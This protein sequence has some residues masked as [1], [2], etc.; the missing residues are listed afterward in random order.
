MP[1]TEDPTDTPLSGLLS[2]PDSP[3]VLDAPIGAGATGTVYRAHLRRPLGTLP[4]ESQVAVKFLNQRFAGDPGAQ[5][6]LLEEGRLGQAI[7]SAYVARIHGVGT[8]RVLG[9]SVTWLVMEYLEGDNL[10]TFVDSGRRAVEDLTRRVGR[11]AALGLA[12]LHARGIVHRDVKP[13]NLHLT[14]EGTVK[15]MDL[16]LAQRI[17]RADL[18]ASAGPAGTLPYS[19]PEVL[20]GRTATPQSDLWALGIVLYEL[21]TGRHPFARGVARGSG[22]QGTRDG[23]SHPGASSSTGSRRGRSA[24]EIIEAVLNATP[25]RPSHRQPR[26]SA[27]L[28]EVILWLMAKDP[29]ARPVAASQLAEILDQ[30]EASRWWIERMARAPTLAAR[31]R[32]RRI[33]RSAPGPFVDRESATRQLDRHHRALLRGRG[34]LVAISGPSGIG[35]RRLLDEA[36]EAWLDRRDA[37]SFVWGVASSDPD[38]GRGQPFPAMLAEALLGERPRGPRVRERIESRLGTRTDWSQAA[39]TRVAGSLAGDAAAL[40]PAD[41]AA[42]FV[43]LLEVL[44]REQPIVLRIDHA[45]HLDGTALR[46]LDLVHRQRHGLPILVLLV[47]GPE[48][49][50]EGT[51][52]V[53]TIE[54]GGLEAEAFVRFATDLFE[55]GEAP[56]AALELAAETFGGSP[57]NAIEA[58]DH[59]VEQGQL[60]GRPGSFFAFDAPLP[61]P[62]APSHLERIGQRLS[63]LPPRQQ[64][65][66]Q[67]AAVLGDRFAVADLAAVIGRPE[68]QVLEDLSVFRGRVVRAVGGEVAF[69]HRAFRDALQRQL[70]AGLRQRLHRLV[71]FA[72]QERNAPTLQIGLHLSRAG[73]HEAC[74]PMLLDALDRLVQSGSK[75]TAQR[76]ANRLRVHL[77]HLSDHAHARPWQLRFAM[78]QARRAR[79]SGKNAAADLSLRRAMGLAQ[80]YGDHAARAD[81]LVEWADMAR[82][83]GQFLAALNLL[84]S[85]HRA[86]PTPG[87]GQPSA[88]AVR[89]HALHAQIMA[90]LGQVDEGV[91]H[92]R[93]AL[94]LAADD[95]RRTRASLLVELANLEILLRHLPTAAKTLDRARHLLSR[96]D[97]PSLRARLAL[98]R[99]RLQELVGTVEPEAYERAIRIAEDADLPE[100]LGRVALARAE[101][102]LWRDSD[103]DDW[104]GEAEEYA[105]R[106][107]D[108]FTAECARVHRLGTALRTADMGTV[109][110]ELGAPELLGWWLLYEARRHRAAGDGARRRIFLDEAVDV[111][112]AATLPLRLNLRILQEAGHRDRA[113]LLVESMALRFPV[114]GGRRRFAAELGRHLD[115]G[116]G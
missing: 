81:A 24:D 77:E 79:R 2:T 25:L 89:A 63:R 13:E 94:L 22:S 113:R 17:D 42:R 57:G 48:G 86:V 98:Q 28:E 105:N 95:D 56:R 115:D 114:G 55:P 78:L 84:D 47:V 15:V 30:G 64:H 21:A 116:E 1:P 80:T 82:E 3:F 4:A 91:A 43:D 112:R 61:I 19:A 12:A 92:L 97:P 8:N 34:T 104:L 11:D 60:Q 51:P 75:R 93:C 23:G 73:E 66:L 109:V 36:I 39:V 101:T 108:R 52:S 53:D 88:T 68:L 102:L 5:D 38:Q 69:R 70:P 46:V 90:G 26:I 41:G 50:P 65:V 72:L 31:G 14:P 33:R 71:A 99:G 9:L 87:E 100:M 76:I 18:A 35:R 96:D 45:E 40:E 62:P 110:E 7:D 10:R 107:G 85:A 111:S 6:R 67:V 16:G 58:L 83:S 37:F 59:L 49:L 74:V 20:A 44:S 29:A 103:A 32:L 106:A 54:L 27:F